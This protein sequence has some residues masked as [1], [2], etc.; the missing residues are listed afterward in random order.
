MVRLCA[1]DDAAQSHTRLESVQGTLAKLP[2][3]WYF[4]A[5]CFF[6]EYGS[7]LGQL[8][9][10]LQEHVVVT[11]KHKD[12]VAVLAR[13]NDKVRRVVD[14][15]RLLVYTLTDG[16]AP[17]CRFVHCAPPKVLLPHLSTRR[18]FA[19]ELSAVHKRTLLQFTAVA[20]LSAVFW[21]FIEAYVIL[22]A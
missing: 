8:V 3:D 18:D 2:G 11:G 13:H 12:A 19:T 7:L 16:W 20:I 22:D 4:R 10:L 15:Q 6:S 1:R 5:V 17:L 14:K 9:A 21:S